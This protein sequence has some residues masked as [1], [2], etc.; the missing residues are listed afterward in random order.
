MGSSETSQPLVAPSELRG[1]TRIRWVDL[2]EAV[3]SAAVGE[4][5]TDVA[6]E[7]SVT[8]GFSPGVASRLTLQDGRRVFVKAISAERN[9]RS[10]ELYRREIAVMSALPSSA[11]APRL[12]WSYDDGEWVLLVLDDI[13]GRMPEQPWQAEE[14]VLVMLALERLSASL[15]PAPF[16]A[17][18]IVDD[19]AENYRSWSV[20]S[21]DAAFVDRLP[22]WARSNLPRLLELESGWAAA[23]RGTTLLHADLRADNLLIIA[24]GDVVVV[25]WPYAVTGAAWVDAVLFLPSVTGTVDLEEIWRGFSPARAAHPDAV[26]AVLAAVAG[27]FIY[28]SMLPD[29]PNIPTLRPHQREKGL[30]ALNWLRSRVS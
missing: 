28:Q 18:S 10:P 24:D 8:G 5:G 22:A 16:P 15:T 26:N 25:D 19:L 4:L 14:L 7:I 20:I 30:A 11:P 6:A 29:P 23:A 13:D 2:P 21:G 12:Q 27:D 9:S 1:P 17:E 3:R